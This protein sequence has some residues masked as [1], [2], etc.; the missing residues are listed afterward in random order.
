[1]NATITLTD[2][3]KSTLRTAAYGAIALISA[4]GAPHKASSEGSIALTTATGLTGHILATAKAREITLK[5]KTV[6][7]LADQVFPALTAAMTLLQAQNPDEA[8][9][10]RTTVLVAVE[11]ATRTVKNGPGPALVA[12]TSKITGALYSA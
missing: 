10:F 7:D 2:Q 11:A 5:G 6:A 3:D 12:M 1:M 9:N 8:E 4:T